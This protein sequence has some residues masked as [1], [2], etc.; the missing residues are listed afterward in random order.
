MPCHDD[1]PD[2]DKAKLQITTRLACILCRSLE[3]L[4]E[5]IPEFA[6]AWWEQH[7]KDDT[8]V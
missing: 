4:G 6:R 5:G 2:P 3:A 7:K 8:E 1:R